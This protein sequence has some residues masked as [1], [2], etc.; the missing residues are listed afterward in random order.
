[1]KKD[2]L[3]NNALINKKKNPFVSFIAAYSILFALVFFCIYLYVFFNDYMFFKW[4]DSSVQHSRALAYYASFLRKIVKTLIFEHRFVVPQWDFSIGMGSDVISTFSY[5]VIGDPINIFSVLVP[6]KYIIYYYEFMTAFR[7]YLAGLSFSYMCS[8]LR[9]KN[10]TAI[11]VSHRLALTRKSNLIIVL[12]NG[13]IIES[14]NHE[15]LIKE[16]GEY[17]R[18]WKA[19]AD[20]YK[21]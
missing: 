2:N 11:M 1:M 4:G 5:Y 20:L 16:N 8:E 6:T 21:T 14:G 9:I 19:Q 13:E 12:K 3:K 17:A 7:M 15:N 10:K 18:M